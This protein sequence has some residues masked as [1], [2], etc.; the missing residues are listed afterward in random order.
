MV[1]NDGTMGFLDG[2]SLFISGIIVFKF[3]FALFYTL[4]WNFRTWCKPYYRKSKTD[5]NEEF[6][7]IRKDRNGA[8]SSDEEEP[9]EEQSKKTGDLDAMKSYN[10]FDQD[11]EGNPVM[12]DAKNAGEIDDSDND[13]EEFEDA[14]AEE[15]GDKELE[16]DWRQKSVQYKYSQQT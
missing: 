14:K 9:E 1:V 5:V 11:G 13:D 4:K 6:K 2:F 3:I 15:E 16:D 10:V 8:V 7:R 12:K